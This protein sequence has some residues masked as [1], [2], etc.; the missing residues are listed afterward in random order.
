MKVLTFVLKLLGVLGLAVL[1]YKVAQTFALSGPICFVLALV[2]FVCASLAAFPRKLPG[3][4]LWV[5][6]LNGPCYG[7]ELSQ[8]LS[9]HS[10]GTV[11][12]SPG[13]LYPVPKDLL[14]VG[15]IEPF[16]GQKQGVSGMARMCFRLTNA[17]QEYIKQSKNPFD[18]SS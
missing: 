18:K 1:A 8:G 17:G 13:A 3:Y 11:I 7:A 9:Q 6:H 5:I 10:R 15:L 14:A 12:L 4:V 2:T 16:D